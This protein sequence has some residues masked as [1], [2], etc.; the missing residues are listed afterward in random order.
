MRSIQYDKQNII[1]SI[2]E[3]SLLCFL[4][5]FVSCNSENAPDCLQN[6]GDLTRIEIE[7][8]DF[9]SITVFER[10]NLVLQQGDAQK[11]EIESGELLL[12]EISAKVEGE[13]LVL[14]NENGCNL[15]RDYGL[16]TIYV[17]SPNIEEIRSSTGLRIL[18][19]GALNYPSLRLISESFNNPETETT[20]GTFDLELQNESVS[21]VVNG[22]AFFDLRGATQNL[23]ITIAAG[24]T[25]IESENLVSEIVEINHRGTNDVNVNA[26]QRL[27]GIIRG[28]GDVISVNRPPQ[29]E[30]EETF[31]GRLIFR[32]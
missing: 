15:F 27:L 29:V 26:Q 20:S 19:Q 21:I 32:D 25:R 23:A 8:A 11:V 18:S 13:R 4:F 3:K 30:V 22:I 1:L 14:R 10:L 24:D 17:T 9:S 5:L 12:D 31:E 7:V 28:Y 2:F 6:A 16:S